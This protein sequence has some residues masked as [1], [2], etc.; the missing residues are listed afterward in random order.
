MSEAM[1]SGLACVAFDYAAAA[2]HV[3]QGDN[4]LKAP[5]RNEG[6]F[7]AQCLR[8]SE[9][10]ALRQSIGAHARRTALD[11]S[12]ERIFVQLE[13]ILLDIVRSHEAYH[14]KVLFGTELGNF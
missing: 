4:G 3:R 13:G 7:V 8:L 9:D 14:E 6:E 5:Y 10:E 11:L 2:E 12:W 1:A